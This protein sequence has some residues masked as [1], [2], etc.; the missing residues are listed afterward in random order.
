MQGEGQLT[1]RTYPAQ[2]ACI[3]VEICDTGPGIPKEIESRIFE[4]FFTTKPPGSGTGLGLNIVYSIIVLKHNGRIQV[5]SRPGE[6]CFQ[7]S[8]PIRLNGKGA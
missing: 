6:T 2:E 5:D 1:L 4:P 3:V 7:V 8:L